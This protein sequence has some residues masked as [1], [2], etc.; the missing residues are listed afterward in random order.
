MG[1]LIVAGWWATAPPN[2]SKMIE[3]QSKV[4]YSPIMYKR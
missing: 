3:L 2:Y 4:Y 1:S